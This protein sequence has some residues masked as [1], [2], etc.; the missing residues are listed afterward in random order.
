[1]RKSTPSTACG[2][3]EVAQEYP[4]IQISSLGLDGDLEVRRLLRRAL[5]DAWPA[6]RRFS[7]RLNS[8]CELEPASS[9][10]GYTAEDGTVF[11]KVRNPADGQGHLYSYSFVLATLLHELTHLSILG[12]GKAFYRQLAQATDACA[13]EPCVRR[14]VRAHVCGELLNAVCDN[15]ARRAKALLA[16]MPEAVAC[17]LPGQRQLPLDYAAHHGRVALTKLLLEARA[18]VTASVDGLPPLARAAARGNTKTARILLEAADSPPAAHPRTRNVGGE[19]RSCQVVADLVP[20]PPARKALKTS[21]S[22]PLL[23]DLGLGAV[24]VRPRRNIVTLSGSLA[25]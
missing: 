9:D 5:R 7:W 19:E 13:A 6:A 14:E 11:V 22:L 20:K 25:L 8:L 15:D 16:V 4:E 3:G 18:D 12:H 24:Q 2:T 23:S 1:M 10:V 21:V 17:R